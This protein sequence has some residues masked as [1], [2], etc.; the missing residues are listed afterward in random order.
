M[1]AVMHRLEIPAFRRWKQEAQ[2]RHPQIC[3]KVKA[4]LS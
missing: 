3:I 1:I 2:K 4:S